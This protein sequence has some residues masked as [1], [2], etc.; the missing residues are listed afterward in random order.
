MN[1]NPD[2]P[3]WQCCC[4]RISTALTLLAGVEIVA[5]LLALAF[6]AANLHQHLK[7]GKEQSLPFDL[8]LIILM[9]FV[10]LSSTLLT[11][12]IQRRQEKLM[13]P[14]LAARVFFVVFVAVDYYQLH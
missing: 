11:V 1:F 12:G 5:S 9:G 6:G 8:S 7:T 3:R 13:Y 4:F 10:A 14:S 2:N